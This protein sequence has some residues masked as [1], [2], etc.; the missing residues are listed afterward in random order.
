M[1]TC[2]VEFPIRSQQDLQSEGLAVDGDAVLEQR[3]QLGVQVG[4][5][6]LEQVVLVAADGRCDVDV[7]DRTLRVGRGRHGKHN[8]DLVAA[9]NLVRIALELDGQAESA[10]KQHP[11]TDPSLPQQESPPALS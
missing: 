10:G 11:Q 9:S 5:H 8:V 2:T 4:E 6:A 1:L 7:A 3:S